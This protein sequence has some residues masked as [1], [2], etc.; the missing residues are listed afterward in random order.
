[1]LD[2]GK[3]GKPSGHGSLA[4]VLLLLCKLGRRSR[5]ANVILQDKQHKPHHQE[6]FQQSYD[7]C[8]GSQALASAVLFPW[9]LHDG[10]IHFGIIPQVE[11]TDYPLRLI[12]LVAK[13]SEP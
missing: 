1:M 2:G 10:K 6:T 13:T 8:L 5:P 3:F 12:I 7:R 9:Y 11:L 4:K